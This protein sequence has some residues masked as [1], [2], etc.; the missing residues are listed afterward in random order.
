VGRELATAGLGVLRQLE[1]VRGMRD[2][3][4]FRLLRPLT[5][6]TIAVLWSRANAVG[7]ER[8]ERFM[9]VLS[10][11][12]LAVSGADLIA[13][14]AQP[15]DAFSAILARALD[16]RLDGRAVG[17]EAEMTNLRRLAIR[18]GLIGLRKDPA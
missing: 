16:D 4:L 15:G 11:T 10:G 7:K 1:S 14:G 2:S 6:E 17:R 9:G 12:R 3:R 8:V 18:G 5:A 13:M